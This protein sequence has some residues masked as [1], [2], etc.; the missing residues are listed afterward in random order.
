MPN[1]NKKGAEWIAWVLATAL[2]VSLSVMGIIWARGQTTELTEGTAE[3]I[4]AREECKMVIIAAAKDEFAGCKKIK[5]ENKGT[6]TIKDFAIRIETKAGL[7]DGPETEELLPQSETPI[8]LSS[9]KGI[10]SVELLPIIEIS[11][12]KL[13]SCTTKR[14]IIQC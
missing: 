6:L 13:A 14:L 11:K 1:M 5:V 3:Y 12:N 7:E 9:Y 2:F 10:K 8:D 4:E